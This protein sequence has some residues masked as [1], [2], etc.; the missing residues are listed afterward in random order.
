LYVL[1][2]IVKYEIIKAG[3]KF[4]ADTRFDPE[5]ENIPQVFDLLFMRESPAL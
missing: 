4:T 3:L 1:R 5:N 2:Y